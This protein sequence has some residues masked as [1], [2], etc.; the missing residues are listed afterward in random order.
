MLYIWNQH[1]I[2]WN[3]IWTHTYIHTPKQSEM[4]YRQVSNRERG[5]ADRESRSMYVHIKDICEM[6]A[7]LQL[8]NDLQYHRYASSS[9]SSRLGLICIRVYACVCQFRLSAAGLVVRSHVRVLVRCIR[10]LCVTLRQHIKL[11]CGHKTSKC[12]MNVILV[13]TKQDMWN[14]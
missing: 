10:S 6:I 13:A 8:P 5:R 4:Q 2:I 3:K 12:I 11:C 1:V 7:I 9:S 14:N